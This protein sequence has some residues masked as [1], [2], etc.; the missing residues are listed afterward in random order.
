[1]IRI[2]LVAV[3]ALAAGSVAT[4]AQPSGV[5]LD[6]VVRDASG[7][8]VAGSR[9]E[10]RS[11]TGSTATVTSDAEGRFRVD[12]LFPGRYTFHAEREGFAPRT[13]VVE[14]MANAV[15]P[16]EIEL[17]TLAIAESLTVVG[18]PG[19]P[20]LDTTAATAS[21]LGLT[22]GETPATVEVITFAQ[23]QSRG[24]RT[25][26]EAIGSVPAV[27]AASLPSSP[28]ITA[29]RGFTGG[30]ISL[31]F[32]GTRIT[33]ATMFT[34]NYDSWSFD[35]IEVLKGPASVLYGEGAIA[36]AINFVPKRSD[37]TTR[38]GEALLSYGSM[39]TPRLAA[40]VTGPINDR[41]AYRADVA[42]GQ[43]D[44]FVD[45]AGSGTFAANGAIDVRLN[46]RTTLGL[47]VDHFRDDYTTG[48][49][50][51]PLVPRAV[52][53]DPTGA[54]TDS[55]DFV[56]D[57]AMRDVNYNVADAVVDAYSTWGRVRLDAALSASWRIQNDAYVYDALR[58]YKNS[59][60]HTFV[61]ATSQISR[62]TVFI[63]HDHRF[64]GNRFAV[65][66][67][68]RPGGRRNRFSAGFEVNYNDFLSPRRF[69][70]T[71]TVD[72]FSP[73]RG[74]LPVGDNAINF[75][76]AG[77]RT[78]F[79]TSIGV[80]SLFVE[81]ALS[82]APRLTLVGGARV[83]RV[84]IERVINDL[85]TGARTTFDRTFEPV[86]GRL[87][88]VVDLAPQTQLFTQ[89]TTAVAPVA[90]VL[91]ISQVNS[92]FELTKGQSFEG[93]VKSTLAGGKINVT[94]SAFWIEQDDIL[95]RDPDNFN[96]TIQ[97]GSQA[98]TGF[99][100]TLSA[101]PTPR[102]RVDLNGS[103]MDARF[104]E[105]IEAGG[106]PTAPATCRR[107]CPNEPPTCGRRTGC[108]RF[109]LRSPAGSATRAASSPTTPIPL[110]CLIG[111]PS[112]RWRAGIW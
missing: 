108:A 95:T 100:F 90:T 72:L 9:I 20:Q 17:D 24:L 39:N 21:R 33:T 111:P 73:G 40:G 37:F 67:D 60:V 43:T 52:A 103:I 3:I 38:R 14:V 11:A 13:V 65:A 57:G 109:R 104:V 97:G 89:F 80:A 98:T 2:L 107:T 61:P 68:A 56:L 112:M 16:I 78:D 35:R 34:R 55:R 93:G 77:N 81:D 31:L 29:I 54:V 69:G 8:V 4:M 59:E 48:Y 41:A 32:D 23:A 92:K 22:A 87:G 36:G 27:T 58:T 1:M 26:V 94:G 49:W 96:V 71:T 79:E 53:R 18:A 76:G 50:G 84:A 7:G 19:A 5:S 46:S 85:N 86:S 99:E 45:D 30:A 83:E 105:L 75:P 101:N 15:A 47:A 44:G 28:G 42:W 102:L 63:A 106:A 25:T 62:S 6:G 110:R 82:A 70:A 74:V 10:A 12:R 66:S 51:T 88:A 64:H 91:L